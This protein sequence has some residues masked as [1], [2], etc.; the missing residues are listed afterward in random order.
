MIETPSNHVRTMLE[1]LR[2]DKPMD[3]TFSASNAPQILSQLIA[4]LGHDPDIITVDSLEEIAVRL[5]QIARKDPAWGW[6]YLRNVLN[7]KLDA[8]QKLIRAMLALG[9]TI[10]GTPSDLAGARSVSVM[11]L[12][13]VKPG[14]LI[15]AD[16][17]VCADPG[18]GIHF[19][20]RSPQQRYHSARC[21][22]ADYKRRKG[23]P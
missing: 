18:C 17:R 1:N 19:V 12:G 21:Q 6:R 8:S 20:P 9:A 14:A 15:L 13:N 22:K 16:S 10:D 7:K 5:S 4:E 11:V 3:K 23:N 2:P